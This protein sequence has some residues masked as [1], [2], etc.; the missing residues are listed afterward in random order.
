MNFA[1]KIF[2]KY[3]IAKFLAIFVP[4]FLTF[5]LVALYIVAEKHIA[6][7]EDL[8]ATR[9]GNQTGRISSLIGNGIMDENPNTVSKLTSTLLADPAVTCVEILDAGAP[10]GAFSQ[11]KNLGCSIMK[12]ERSVDVS[13]PGDGDAKLRVGFSSSEIS[14]LRQETMIFA[15]LAAIFGSLG[16]IA[17]GVFGFNYA[18]GRPIRALKHAIETAETQPETRAD[19]TSQNEIGQ[20]CLS[21]NALQDRVAKEQQKTIQSL[22]NLQTVYNGTPALLFT[23]NAT[24]TILSASD[25]WLRDTGYDLDDVIGNQLDALLCAQSR[26][27]LHEKVFPAIQSGNAIRELPLCLIYQDGRLIDVLLSIDKDL[28]QSDE[29][30]SFVCVMNDVSLLREAE[31][32]LHLSAI[33]DQ[34]TEL[35][36]RRGLIDY[37]EEIMSGAHQDISHCAILFVDLDNFKTV[38]DTHGH[39]VG[40]EV[41]RTCAARIKNVI[42]H[43]GRAARIGGD[44]FAVILASSA[45]IKNFETLSKGIV[46]ELSKPI[47][48]GDISCFV[49]ASIGIAISKNFPEDL[50]ETLRL[51]DQAMYLA[52]RSGKNRTCLYDEQR[53]SLIQQHA[54]YVQLVQNGIEEDAFDIYF[55]PIIDLDNMRPYA[56]ES[57]LRVT[58]SQKVPI[59]IE[60]LIKV[61]EDTGQMAVLGTW[62]FK[63]SISNF[64]TLLNQ[65]PQT[66]ISLSINLSP[67]QL[68]ADFVQIVI[69][70]MQRYPAM[71]G[72]LILEIT[73]TAAMHEFDKVCALLQEL[74]NAGIRIALDDFG[75]GY[76]SL[77]YISKLPIDILKLD[78]SFVQ[79]TAALTGQISPQ[80]SHAIL[81]RA[82]A[83]LADELGL[84][85]VAEGIETIELMENYHQLGVR[86]GQGYLF[87]RPLTLSDT[88]MWLKPY[89]GQHQT[90]QKL[91]A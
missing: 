60:N 38:N 71:R 30:A 18:V 13:I 58:K 29:Q 9:I 54:E 12:P 82:L 55:Q 43:Y 1:S 89:S 49:G 56:F 31:K 61:A 72:K 17:T 35:P 16:A 74:R 32:N 79:T 4:I 27:V 33:T 41:L 6:S 36:N 59:C 50:S 45:P 15:A 11:P 26:R 66:Q 65:Y 67:K 28:R 64:Q 10:R 48:V 76:S 62:I 77:S 23:M 14:V 85:V 5:T 51:S 21:F 90:A 42:G 46:K 3:I 84:V 87:S 44:E 57:L 20:L 19:M 52:K 40:D 53:A 22:E 69:A 34:L 39:R 8:L 88:E 47:Y 73:E 68:N 37:F 78:K 81:V 63:K 70:H 83:R 86:L 91:L 2:S 25:F 24:G 75:T 80:D 7:A